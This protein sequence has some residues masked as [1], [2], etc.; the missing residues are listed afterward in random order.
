MSC[1]DFPRAL[2]GHCNYVI[3]AV[4]LSDCLNKLNANFMP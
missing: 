3:M 1:L 4:Q 2:K